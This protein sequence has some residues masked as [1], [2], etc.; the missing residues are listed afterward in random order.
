[1]AGGRRIPHYIDIEGEG[2]GGTVTAVENGWRVPHRKE[3]EI[4]WPRTI[5]V[6]QTS[7]SCCIPLYK[8]I[9][10]TGVS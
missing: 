8:Y 9:V 2:G 3:M 6:L 1:M 7:V 5:Q 10:T 4:Q